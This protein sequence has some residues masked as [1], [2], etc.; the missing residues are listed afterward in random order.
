MPMA[1]WAWDIEYHNLCLDSYLQELWFVS[2]AVKRYSAY[3]GI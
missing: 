3:L 1:F 2:S